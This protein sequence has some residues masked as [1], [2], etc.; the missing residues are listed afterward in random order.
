MIEKIPEGW[1]YLDYK[2]S[3]RKKIDIYN[4]IQTKEYQEK[5]SIPIVDQGKTKIAGYIDEEDDKFKGELPVI[6]FGDHTLTV[7]FVDYEFAVGADGTKIIHANEEK[8][9]PKFLYYQILNTKIKSEGYQ[10]HFK[11]LKDKK[12][13]QP[14]I[15]EQQKIASILLKVDEQIQLTE[16]I[17][18]KTE[19]LKKGLMQQLFTKGIG[20]TAFKQTDV[21]EIPIDWE[22]VTLG[23]YA[24]ITKLAGFEYTKYFNSYK[25]E[26]EIIVVRGTNITNNEL[27][28]SDVKT[29]P[30]ETSEKLPRS[31]LKRGDLVFAY[32]GTIGPVYLIKESNRYHLGPNTARI[33]VDQNI[34]P[35]YAFHYFSSYLM[36]NE[37][38]RQ[39]SVS[40]QPSLS[41]TKIRSF[42]FILPKS[43][44]EQKQIASILS[45]V[46]E[47]IQDK[48]KELKHLHKLLKSLMQDLLTGKV[49][50]SV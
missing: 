18:N 29:I 31:Q 21:G 42:R 33:T 36:K 46:D 1:H 22:I 28:L 47:Q 34:E 37:I 27:D 38:Y 15:N 13:L 45:K 19:E 26:G 4:K 44:E 43:I 49:R 9:I 16:S 8:F 10:R 3:T 35:Q 7:K 40:A 30:K 25:D 41:M 6:I 32:V 20:H 5:G 2:H 23:D 50:V 12:F 24:D 14:P 48:R 11:Y 39:I 17:I